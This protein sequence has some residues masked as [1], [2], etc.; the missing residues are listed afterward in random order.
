VL[1][2]ESDAGLSALQIAKVNRE[3]MPVILAILEEEV[4]KQDSAKVPP[5]G[6]LDSA[7]NAHEA[8]NEFTDT[9][10]EEFTVDGEMWHSFL[11]DGSGMHYFCNDATGPSPIVAAVTIDSDASSISVGYYCRRDI[12]GRSTCRPRSPCSR[13]VHFAAAFCT[14]A[15][16]PSLVKYRANVLCIAAEEAAREAEKRQQEQEE[17]A[18][19]AAELSQAEIVAVE[20]M[21]K[22]VDLDCN[23]TIDLSELRNLFVILGF[24]D[25]AE[26]LADDYMVRQALCVLENR[27]SLS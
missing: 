17:A 1:A 23:G 20:L 24:P 14:N 22:Q 4:A 12:L 15:T 6:S 25:E 11:D 9:W 5:L 10:A 8:E 16:T 13:C 7:D 18:A 21:F 2:G 19:A 26:R 3:T 27:T